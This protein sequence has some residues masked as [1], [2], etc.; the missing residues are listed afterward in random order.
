M[1]NSNLV[2]AIKVNGKVL[3]EFDDT[4]AI[5]FGSEYTV[6]LKNLSDRRVAVNVSIDGTDAIDGDVIINGN[7]SLELKRFV[8]SGNLKA[9]NAFKF[10]EKTQKIEE[11]RGNRAE[12][13]LITISYKF[14]RV[15]PVTKWVVGTPEV[16]C[17]SGIMRGMKSHTLCGSTLSAISNG[18]VSSNITTTAY[19]A[20][21]QTSKTAQM[22]N[23]A[24]TNIA[25]ITAPGSIV[26]QQFV[27]VSNFV[28]DNVSHTMTLKMTGVNAQN[29]KVEAPVV[30][31]KLIKCS[32]CG[33]NTRQTAKFCHECGASV[34]IV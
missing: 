10:I 22:F 12:D 7:S 33:T 16:Y 25:G 26:E 34:Q 30:V 18:S 8:K 19:N 21:T 32:M 3:R 6:L 27:T 11:Y 4:V 31:K 13:G 28:S 29:L 23:H 20:G 2:V 14:E 9:G 17:D 5:P 15:V 1:F 24:N